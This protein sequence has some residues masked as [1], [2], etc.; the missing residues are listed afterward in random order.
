MNPNFQGHI[1]RAKL[2][3]YASSTTS[4]H[5]S[6]LLDSGASSHIT[7]NIHI[8]QNPQPYIGPEKVYIGD[9]QGLPILHT[10]YTFLKTPSATFTLKNVLHVLHLKHDLL[11]ANMFLRDN[12]CSLT[13]NPFDFI[14]KDLIMGMMLFRAHVVVASIH[15]LHLLQLQQGILLILQ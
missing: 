13:L 6:W 9:G 8:L 1:P 12:W 5:P 3:M 4:S 15:S 14:V 7:N 11:S 10:S 2:A